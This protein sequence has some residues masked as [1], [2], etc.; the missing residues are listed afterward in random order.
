VLRALRGSGRAAAAAAAAAAATTTTS[1]CL[2]TSALWL[3]ASAG[4]VGTFCCGVSTCVP[5]A[6]SGAAHHRVAPAGATHAHGCAERCCCSLQLHRTAV[7]FKGSEGV[8]HTHVATKLCD[9]VLMHSNAAV[10]GCACGCRRCWCTSEPLA[11]LGHERGLQR[12]QLTM[13]WSTAAAHSHNITLEAL[14]ASLIGCGAPGRA[15][16]AALCHV[17]VLLIDTTRTSDKHQSS[18]KRTPQALARHG[19]AVAVLFMGLLAT[20]TGVL[21]LL[22]VE[23]MPDIPSRRAG[24]HLQLCRTYAV[25][26]LNCCLA[27]L[28]LMQ[29]WICARVRLPNRTHVL[30][31]RHV[32]VAGCCT[33]ACHWCV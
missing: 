12:V 3:R 9:P 31:V 32:W 10:G 20:S 15:R 17:P 14:W 23:H 18:T 7:S 13:I 1:S 24:I 11:V 30:I 27:K 28:N 6:P 25:S 29:S 4:A 19:P 21:V 8:W 26:C 22:S 5:V 2:S 16:C 33:A